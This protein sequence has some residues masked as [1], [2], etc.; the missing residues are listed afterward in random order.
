[1]AAPSGKKKK[2]SG[3]AGLGCATGGRGQGTIA[4]DRMPES[5]QRAMG[6]DKFSGGVGEEGTMILDHLDGKPR[7]FKDGGG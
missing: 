2:E 7:F 1:M 4:Q 3:T 5:V 6:K